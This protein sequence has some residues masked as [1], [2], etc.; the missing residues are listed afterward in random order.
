MVCLTL[1]CIHSR[2]QLV[3]PRPV[4]RFPAD[5]DMAEPPALSFP[6]LTRLQLW[7]CRFGMADTRVMVSGLQQLEVL[8]MLQTEPLIQLRDAGALLQ[9]PRLREVDL[10]YSEL[11]V[12]KGHYLSQ[13]P[14]YLSEHVAEQLLTLQKAAPRIDWVLRGFMWSRIWE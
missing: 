7:R 8:Q 6:Q 4:C 1:L 10:S 13:P 2:D 3:K 5:L 9:L 14:D 11:W 12:H